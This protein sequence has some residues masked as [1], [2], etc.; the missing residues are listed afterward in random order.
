MLDNFGGWCHTYILGQ[1]LLPLPPL[2]LMNTTANN[3]IEAERRAF[4]ASIAHQIWIARDK[5]IFQQASVSPSQLITKVL[6]NA[7][8]YFKSTSLVAIE[9]N[10]DAAIAQSK[11]AVDYVIRDNSRGLMRAGGKL[12]HKIIV[13]CGEL[14]AAWLGFFIALKELQWIHN[15]S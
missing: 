11:A 4:Y 8:L 5:R 14:T 9:V 2:E 12:L 7:M 10:L 1:T 6:A 15:L 13:P 3:Q